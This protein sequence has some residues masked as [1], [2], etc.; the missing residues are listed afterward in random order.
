MIE[1]EVPVLT[2]SNYTDVQEGCTFRV[3]LKT[4]AGTVSKM[5]AYRLEF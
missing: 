4:C 5:T 1:I 3:Y 2:G